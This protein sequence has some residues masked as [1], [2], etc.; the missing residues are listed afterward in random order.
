MK[1]TFSADYEAYVSEYL[2]TIKSTNDDRYD[3]LT[4]KNSTWNTRG[5][6]VGFYFI[7]SLMENIKLSGW[8]I[9]YYIFLKLRVGK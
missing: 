7:E 1:L 6:F 3:I 4:N 8:A 5:L 2:M 9:L